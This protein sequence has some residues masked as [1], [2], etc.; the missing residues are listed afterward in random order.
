MVQFDEWI[1]SGKTAFS[2]VN[3]LGELNKLNDPIILNLYE[4]LGQLGEF[5][6]TYQ[7]VDYYI[8]NVDG[9]DINGLGTQLSPWE[10][11]GRAL[12]FLRNTIIKHRVQILAA[13]TATVGQTT[14]V[15]DTWFLD[16]TIDG[17]SLAIIGVGVPVET[18]AATEVR[19]DTA[20]GDGAFI[21]NQTD[22]AWTTDD[23]IGEF[24]LTE[25]GN[26]FAVH[27]NTAEDLWYHYVGVGVPTP[28]QHIT[29]VVPAVRFTLNNLNVKSN[30]AFISTADGR[31]SPLA[32]VNC[33]LD[34]ENSTSLDGIL[35]LNYSNLWMDFVTV[36]F[37]DGGTRQVYCN[38]TNINTWPPVNTNLEAASES[39]VVNMSDMD[40]DNPGLTLRRA[41][42]T[43][44]SD[45]M[46][47]MHNSALFVVTNSAQ[48]LVR[49]GN[50]VLSRCAGH[51]FAG[52]NAH[53]LESSFSYASTDD[54]DNGIFLEQCD[55]H[56]TSIYIGHAKS[57]IFAD[58]ARLIIED[59]TECD[60][61]CDYVLEANPFVQCKVT[62]AM[63]GCVGNTDDIRFVGPAAAVDASWP[64]D[65]VAVDDGIATSP[66]SI[67]VRKD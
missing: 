63:V 36:V 3:V 8:N 10:T 37:K 27:R 32:I 17:G 57:A 1:Q 34:F 14:Y 33:Y 59:G 13:D 7:N 6:E 15:E 21:L 62:G 46:V 45:T 29:G 43:I 2:F 52:I 40:Y 44:E 4:L 48:F 65:G 35:T 60:A 49:S 19:F 31:R 55:G 58:M 38:E 47:W 50:G 24:M 20:L 42:K 41:T 51:K 54:G 28:T 16:H 67:V 5:P 56:L 66:T 64:A 23:W 53:L 26:A 61:N 22:L 9:D 30:S 18:K 25:G 39:G 11:V 12:E